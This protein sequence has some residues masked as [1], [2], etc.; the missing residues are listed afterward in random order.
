MIKYKEVK[1][2]DFSKNEMH[3]P[4]DTIRDFKKYVLYLVKNGKRVKLNYGDVTWRDNID[5][6]GMEFSTTLP[7]N[8][9]DRHMARYDIAEVGDK[10]I[11]M[12]KKNEIFQG[13]ITTVDFDRYSKKIT[14]HDYAYYLNKSKVIIQFNKVKASTAIS[15]LCKK[16]NVPVGKIDNMSTNITEIYNNQSVSDIIKDILEKQEKNVGGKYRMEMR[17]GKLYVIKHTNLKIKPM[18][19]PAPNVSIYDPRVSF[20]DISRTD[21]LD[22]MVNKVI[23]IEEKDKKI[24]TLATTVDKNSLNKYGLFQEVVSVDK[25]EAKNANKIA[26]RTLDENKGVQQTISITMPGDDKVRAG[27]VIAI[28]NKTYGLKGDYLITDCSHEYKNN[29]RYMKLEVKRA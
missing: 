7:R 10:I 29:N 21:T 14:A 24:R 18:F 12:N 19:K 13:I 25:E 16:N 3:R 8:Q 2:M 4:I 1:D 15:R 11:F 23:V 20:G 27:R 9:D 22:G 28:E 5:T 17:S 6:L 26:K